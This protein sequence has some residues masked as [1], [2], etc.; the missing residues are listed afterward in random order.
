MD[1]IESWT[2]Y[3][4]QNIKSKEYVKNWMDD[5]QV[6]WD[7]NHPKAFLNALQKFLKLNGQ[8]W[9]SGASWALKKSLAKGY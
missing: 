7:L 4:V 1:E 6:S 2:N 9:S 3:D 5:I 8:D